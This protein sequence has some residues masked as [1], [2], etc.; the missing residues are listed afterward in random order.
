M[1]FSMSLTVISP[2]QILCCC[3]TFLA[4]PEAFSRLCYDLTR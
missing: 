1:N 4:F 2:M 3:G